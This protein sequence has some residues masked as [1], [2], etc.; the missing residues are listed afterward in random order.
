MS[1]TVT[2]TLSVGEMTE[3]VRGC[4]RKS[5]EGCTTMFGTL[6]SPLTAEIAG[7]VDVETERGRA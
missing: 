2:G 7:A 5:E 6:L 3:L 1:D 4:V